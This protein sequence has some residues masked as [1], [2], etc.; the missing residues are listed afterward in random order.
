[1]T[2]DE[3]LELPDDAEW[4]YEVV[5]G[6]L[7]RMPASR[8]EAARVALRLA[9]AL[10]TYVEDHGLGEMTGRDVRSDAGGRANADG[11]RA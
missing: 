1:M 2:V 5:D 4:Q 9:A 3:L 10:F 6:R 7:V 8:W 11:S